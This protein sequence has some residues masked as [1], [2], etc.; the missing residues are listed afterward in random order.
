MTDASRVAG[1][2]DVG[3]QVPGDDRPEPTTVLSPIVTR[4]RTIAP[5]PSQT[6]SPMVIGFADSHFDRGSGSSGSSAT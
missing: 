5:L 1:R 2:H 3:R 4:G 6:L